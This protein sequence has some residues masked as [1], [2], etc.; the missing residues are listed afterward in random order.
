MSRR[1][2]AAARRAV[3][4]GDRA[5]P[6]RPPDE[7]AADEGEAGER[8]AGALGLVVELL[9][10]QGVRVAQERLRVA[11]RP[12]CVRER[13]DVRRV[14]DPGRQRGAYEPATGRPARAP[15]ARPGCGAA[16]RP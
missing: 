6:A 1:R 10:Q 13:P 15:T 14:G 16:A 11:Q 7:P 5:L 4:Q 8:G 9:E 3:E 2:T 12:P